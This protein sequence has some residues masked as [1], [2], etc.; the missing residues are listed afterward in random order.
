MLDGPISGNPKVMYDANIHASLSEYGP[1][2][3]GTTKK[4]SWTN[5]QQRFAKTSIYLNSVLKYFTYILFLFKVTVIFY[6]T[7]V[8]VLQYVIPL[9]MI[10]F[11]T[12]F[13]KT[14]G[15]LISFMII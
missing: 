9:I 2:A 10:L 8:V 7:C 14:L 1:R 3:F 6:Y 15:D 11:F 13:Y 12:F 4:R 5:H